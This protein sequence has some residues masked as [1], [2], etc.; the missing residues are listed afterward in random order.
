[1]SHYPPITPHLAITDVAAALDFYPKAFDATERLRLSLPDG[2]V[3][4][5]ELEFNGALVTIGAAGEMFGLS[6]PD[7]D[8]PAEVVITLSVPD[9]D[10]AYARALDAGATSASEPADQFH[11]DRT[12][13]VR[14]PFG[15]KWTF[16]THLEDVDPEEMQRRLT[17][18]M[19]GS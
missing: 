4:H 2:S 6:Q 1:M 15:H 18:L 13:A 7:G 9:T 11:G 3:A 10:A 5:A 19:T 17:A 14:D 8:G 16:Q 12:A